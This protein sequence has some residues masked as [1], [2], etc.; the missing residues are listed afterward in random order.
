[1]SLLTMRARPRVPGKYRT[2]VLRGGIQNM[3]APLP[4][5]RD[6]PMIVT[7]WIDADDL[8]PF[9][10]LRRRF[11]PPDR[12]YLEAHLTLF[13]HINAA[14]REGFLDLA[15]RVCALRE[16]FSVAVEPPFLLGR[17]VAYRV[18]SDELMRLRE[19][20]RRPVAGTL[21]PQD[22]RPWKSPHLT[23]Q[24]K[25]APAE[26]QRLLRHLLPRYEPCF[27]RLLG[28]SCYTYDGGPWTLITRLPFGKP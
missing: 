17:G 9:N 26:A 28:L 10:D 14:D 5:P 27:L 4:Q 23:V 24:N 16:P 20:L 3:P 7:A 25:V 1:M 11:F 8:R 19:D 21:T 6:R 18:T 22:A 13:H 15:R 12:N 2:P